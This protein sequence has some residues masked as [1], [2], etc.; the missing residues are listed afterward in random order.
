[1]LNEKRMTVDV[2]HSKATSL[3][4][5]FVTSTFKQNR[6]DSMD[7]DTSNIDVQTTT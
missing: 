2:D 7:I 4:W 3:D 1:M 5:Q 6:V